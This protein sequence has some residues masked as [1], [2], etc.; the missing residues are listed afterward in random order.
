MIRQWIGIYA[1]KDQKEYQSPP[2]DFPGGQSLPW[3][4]SRALPTSQFMVHSIFPNCSPPLCESCFPAFTFLPLMQP[5]ASCAEPGDFCPCSGEVRGS[6][7][8]RINLLTTWWWLLGLFLFNSF[9]KYL[10]IL[11]VLDLEYSRAAL[12]SQRKRDN[13]QVKNFSTAKGVRCPEGTTSSEDGWD[14]ER[15]VSI[16]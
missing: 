11:C 8:L 12:T 10:L 6:L 4:G 9:N 2:A 3:A 13:A 15:S 14:S 5:A 1:V 16:P 7:R